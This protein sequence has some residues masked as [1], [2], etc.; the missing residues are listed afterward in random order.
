MAQDRQGLSLTGGADAIEAYERAVDH[1][2]RFQAEVVNEIRASLAA[3][4]SFAMGTVL[5]A[6]L[7][8]MSTDGGD[9]VRARQTLDGLAH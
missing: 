8:L 6:Y 2:L 7:S 9:V 4:P 5:S 3:D 1:L